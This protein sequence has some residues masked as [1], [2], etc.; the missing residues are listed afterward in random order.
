MQMTTSSVSGQPALEGEH[1]VGG[2]VD[3]EPGEAVGVAVA[4]RAGRGG[5]PGG[6]SVPH[7]QVHALVERVL[8][9]APVQLAVVATTPA[10]RPAPPP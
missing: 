7:Q 1:A 9:Q 4:A 5:A 10:A 3:D 8:Q 2:V 6:G